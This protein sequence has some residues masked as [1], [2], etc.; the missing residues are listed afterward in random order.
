MQTA[1]GCP[2]VA[3]YPATPVYLLTSVGLPDS[4][5]Y[6]F[7]YEPTTT[8]SN[9]VTGRLA[10][11]TLPTG[12]TISYTYS[13]GNH[14]ITCGD[15]SA[16]GLTRV[17][18]DGTWTYTRSG[19]TTTITDP[20]T[21]TANQT[22]LTFQGIYETQHQ[23]YQGSSASGTLLQTVVTCYNGN[24]T[25]CST[26]PVTLPISR[27][28][29]FVQLPNAAGLQSRTDSF[30]NTSSG[31]L[32]EMDQYA[33]GNGAPGA[34]LRKTTIN[35]ATLTNN[36]LNRPSQVT[37][38]DNSSPAKTLSQTTYTYD[39][40]TP[41]PTSG[42]PQHVA[43]TGSRGNP[44]TITSLVGTSSLTRHVSYYD[45]GN[46][47]QSTDVNGGITTYNYAS[48]TSSCSNSFPTSITS[49]ISTLSQSMTW[50]CVGAVQTSATDVNGNTSYS[51]FTTDSKFW[52]PESLQDAAGNVTSLTYTG[53]T[54]VEA[55]L[56]FNAGNSVVDALSVLDS[57]GRAS[58]QQRRQGPGVSN[59]DSTQQTYDALGRPN[60]GFMPY[61][62]A[63]VG[64]SSPQ[65][66][67]VTTA[68][69][70]A[71]SRPLTVTD[72]GGGSVTFSYQPVVHV[73][74]FLQGGR[75]NRVRVRGPTKQL[76]TDAENR[77]LQSRF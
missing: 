23:V 61:L 16:S 30:Y 64:Q 63:S 62:G 14:G 51:N 69:Y 60:Q 54:Q 59:F 34:L 68:S 31:V 43:I 75:R 24:T 2:N 52:R 29:V 73:V 50:N 44:T 18:P 53:E 8:G 37:V 21:P 58:V 27:R 40:G 41:Q 17:T 15:G 70:N 56:S 66:T 6:F 33:Y 13:G 3:D 46:P 49:P 57:Q 77:L 38:Q 67:P 71:L 32:T 9:N 36:I 48:G 35:Y 65:G 11:V 39:E 25:N 4:T 28:T 74:D 22:V 47:Y 1:F 10:S 76:V 42:T 20:T 45:T 72:A 7:T 12:G 5:S 26:T 19:A 55:A